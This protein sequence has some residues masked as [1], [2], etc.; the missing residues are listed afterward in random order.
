MKFC[1]IASIILAILMLFSFTACQKE[2]NG[3]GTKAPEGSSAAP[4]N[5]T[6]GKPES[7]KAP[8]ESTAKP[9][10]TTKKND[11]TTTPETD[12]PLAVDS[13]SESEMSI[14]R[15][16]MPQKLPDNSDFSILTRMMCGDNP[17]DYQV[18]GNSSGSLKYVDETEGAVYGKA[19]R[20][21]GKADAKDSRGEI[22]INPNYVNMVPGARGILF[23]V[24]FSH[25]KPAED[26]KMCASVTINVNKIRSKGADGQDGSAIAWYYQD[27]TWTQTTNINAC[28]LEIPNNFKGWIYVPATSFTQSDGE[29][30]DP[31]TERFNDKFFVE[32][33]RCY[34]DGYTYDADSYVIFDEIT[35]IK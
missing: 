1:R 6:A 14:L 20:F 27:G 32:N 16:A 24:D 35:F 13:I 34:T 15:M 7:S 10:D 21:A 28:R 19:F 31:T 11:E 4:A 2:N 5:T 9:T 17:D 8:A 18:S 30:W 25:I 29:Y 12:P 23:Y 3:D 26:K 33:M 22:Q